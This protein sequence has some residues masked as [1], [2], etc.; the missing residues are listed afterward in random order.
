MKICVQR[1]QN[2]NSIYSQA[3]TNTIVM[4]LTFKPILINMRASGNLIIEQTTPN[5]HDQSCLN[6]RNNLRR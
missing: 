5:L 1:L 4:H 6:S 3:I 2:L